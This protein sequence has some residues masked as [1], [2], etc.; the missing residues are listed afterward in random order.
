MNKDST[1]SEAADQPEANAVALE[2][3]RA[4]LAGGSADSTAEGLLSVVT[5]LDWSALDRGRRKHIWQVAQAL[6]EVP[7]T[8][9]ALPFLQKVS[10]LQDAPEE[11]LCMLVRTLDDDNIRNSA[12]ANLLGRGSL[13]ARARS[14]L[15]NHVLDRWPVSEQLAVLE[16][17]HTM[18]PGDFRP[19]LNL[20]RHCARAGLTERVALLLAE[21]HAHGEPKHSL[22][23]FHAALDSG[24]FA[25]ACSLYILRADA[26]QDAPKAAGFRLLAKCDMPGLEEWRPKLIDV[27]KRHYPHE[28]GLL[29]EQSRVTRSDAKAMLQAAKSRNWQLAE[30]IYTRFASSP[31]PRP[32]FMRI[33]II[34]YLLERKRIAEALAVLAKERREESYPEQFLALAIRALCELQCWGEAHDLCMTQIGDIATSANLLRALLEAA[35]RTER[36]L[37]TLAQLKAQPKPWTPEMLHIMTSVTEDLAAGGVGPGEAAEDAA[38]SADR[39]MR[40]RAKSPLYGRLPTLKSRL[41]ISYCVDRFYAVPALVSVLS[42]VVNNADLLRDARIMILL[43]SDAEEYAQTFADL[44]EHLRVPFLIRRARDIAPESESLDGRYGFFTAGSQL[45]RAAYFRIFL[46]QHLAESGLFDEILYIDSDT[47]VRSGLRR[48]FDIPLTRPLMARPGVGLEYVHG[49]EKAYGLLKPYF[50]SGVLRLVLRH[51]SLLPA[52]QAALTAIRETPDQLAFHDQCALNIGFNGLYEPMPPAFNFLASPTHRSREIEGVE[53]VILHHLG[54]PKPWDSAYTEDASEWFGYYALARHLADGGLPI[55]YSREISPRSPAPSRPFMIFIHVPKTGGTSIKAALGDAFGEG[56]VWF[57]RTINKI[58]EQTGIT[59]FTEL[60]RISSMLHEGRQLVGGHFTLSDIP[61]ELRK[62][63]IITGVMREPVARAL[64]YYAYQRARPETLIG[65]RIAGLTLRQALDQPPFA[66]ALQDR[67]IRMLFGP[68]EDVAA[69]KSCGGQK[70]IIGKHEFMGSYVAALTRSSGKAIP[71]LKPF[72]LS[73][74]GY[75]DELSRQPEFEDAL[76]I[77]RQ[78]THR[79]AVFYNSFGEVLETG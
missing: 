20:V 39:I 68:L 45:S 7:S 24:A 55:S 8:P 58:T 44:G 34:R 17:L 22:A 12:A 21:G 11:L 42:L 37:A 33:A 79:D 59:H 69:L 25:E 66:H 27:L 64:S 74:P 73:P 6:L 43:D 1:A 46:A 67:Q 14:I 30:E 31:E 19:Y 26:Y 77:I 9:S 48:L 70:I 61:A 54:F 41:C 4:L 63:S 36:L 23:R 65:G 15:S 78:I 13:G 18:N 57:S 16:R 40:I 51:K 76:E 56:L 10:E 49:L 62:A 3:L 35:R 38:L 52:L 28:P 2:N 5:P 47:I 53:P 50:N 71:A 72:N 60:S 32:P 75:L 29:H